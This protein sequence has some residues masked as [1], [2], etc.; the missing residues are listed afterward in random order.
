MNKKLLVR[1]LLL[2]AI[3]GILFIWG[4]TLEAEYTSFNSGIT[5][6]LAYN[7]GSGKAPVSGQID[8]VPFVVGLV[9]V[10]ALASAFIEAKQRK[11]LAPA[12]VVEEVRPEVEASSEV[13]KELVRPKGHET[14]LEIILDH[15]YYMVSKGLSDEAI[16]AK[17]QELGLSKV[18]TDHIVHEMR[19]EN[20]QLEKLI[21]YVKYQIKKKKS[22]VKL[23][24]SLLKKGWNQ[25]IVKLVLNK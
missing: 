16:R 18:V 7:A 5:S 21:N 17:L 3:A 20:N 12:Q 15:V 11:S 14:Q 13:K 1:V 10:M 2:L 19:T 9:A 22:V 24:Q 25:D 8:I 6:Y 4:S 23:R